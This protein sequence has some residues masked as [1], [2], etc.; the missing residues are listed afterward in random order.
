ML[1]N[2]I[3]E[4]FLIDDL[5]NI[6]VSNPDLFLSIENFYFGANCKFNM[7][8]KGSSVQKSD[9]DNFITVKVLEFYIELASSNKN[10][11]DLDDEVLNFTEILD[12]YTVFSGEYKSLVAIIHRFPMF[13]KESSLE[14]LNT[15]WRLLK[16]TEELKNIELNPWTNFGR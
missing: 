1:R 9:L 2:F 7:L 4:E 13:C 6:Y 10:R 8:E 3:K 14:A 5:H 16:D 15:E 12:P 11:F